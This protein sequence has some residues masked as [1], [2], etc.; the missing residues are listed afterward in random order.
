MK[1]MLSLDGPR[2]EPAAGKPQ[3]IV[4]LLHGYGADGNDLISLAPLWA[5]LLPHTLFVSPHAPFSCEINPVGKQWYGFEGATP[6]MILART[7]TA[8]SLI[9]F[10]L[11]A[12]IEETGVPASKVA[13][14][15]FSQGAMMALHVAPR[16]R[17]TLAGVV[18]FSGALVAPE[19]LATETI[20]RPPVLLVHG[21]A[22]PVV[23]FESMQQAAK[24]LRAAGFR[25]ATEIRANVP[26]AI[27]Q[28]GLATG[29]SFL[30]DA[31]AQPASGSA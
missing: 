3:S 17:E 13:L 1:P 24:A 21:D 22:D 19:L 18:G 16:R 30:V 23:P 29:G 31:L 28:V 5:R 14:T 20:T 11:D 27:D 26:H 7:R 9:G 15:G 6:E 12:L 8:A 25:V 2:H 10:Y 4:V